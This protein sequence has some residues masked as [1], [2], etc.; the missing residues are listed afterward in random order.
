MLFDLHRDGGRLVG[1]VD[2][3]QDRR[4]QALG[5]AEQVRGAFE[6]TGRHAA[7]GA[8]L[9]GR[10]RRDDLCELLE[11]DGARLDELVIYP[12]GSDELLQ[13]AVQD[14]HVRAGQRREVNGRFPRDRREPRVDDQEP[15]R[16]RPAEPVEHAHPQD[17][18]GLRDVV[19]VQRNRVRGVHVGVRA[20]LTVGTERLLQRLTCGRRAHPGV[21][22]EVRRG[23]AAAHE[24]REGVVLLQEELPGRVEAQRPRAPL[25]QQRLRPLH[26]E[27]HGSVPVAL[28]EPAVH[29]N[30]GPREPLARVVGL[31]AVEILR[32][33]PAVVDPVGRATSHPDDAA[34][35]DGDVH[36]VTVAVQHRRAL[37]PP[38]HVVR[39]DTVSEERVLTGRP[40]S[41]A[42]KRRA[43]APRLG[44]PVKMSHGCP[45]RW[46]ALTRT[47]D[48]VRAWC[49]ACSSRMRLASFWS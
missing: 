8:G 28:D 32:V 22:V 44:D 19:A 34:V 20:G 2:A 42:P 16:V 40:L 17:R 18:L 25:R 24:R 46:P 27:T 33:E 12:V 6:V 5:A 11:P 10:V 9:I 45:L 41:V 30:E 14:G 36:R 47:H 29:P 23:K 31:P 15:G 48:C 43:G 4:Q 35:L 37:H 26:D 1:L 21:P 3:L 13:Q 38:V 7:D 49:P 39:A